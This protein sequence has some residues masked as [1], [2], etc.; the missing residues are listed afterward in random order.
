MEIDDIRV[1]L[2]QLIRVSG[3]PSTD[4]TWVPGLVD[5]T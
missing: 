4:A 1:R 3:Y 5:P 2:P